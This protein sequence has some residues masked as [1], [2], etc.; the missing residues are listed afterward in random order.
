MGHKKMN[1]YTYHYGLKVRIYPS[2]RQKEMIRRNSDAARSVYNEMV[3][4]NKEISLFGKLNLHI[5]FIAKRIEELRDR[6]ATVTA[7]KNRFPWLCH[8]DI[9]AQS[10]ANARQNYQKAWRQF[11]K[12]HTSGVPRFHKKEATESYQTNPH[13][14]K[15]KPISLFTSNACF[16]D[17]HHL[18]LPKLKRIRFQCSQKMLQKIFAMETKKHQI[19]RIGTITIAK[20]VTGD[21]FASFQLGS[22]EPFVEPFV[23]TGKEVGIDL[24]IENFYADSNG[25]ILDNPSYY[26]RQ[27]RR[28]VNAQRKLSRRIA[29]AKKEHRSIHQAKNIEKQR[30]ILAKL[31][32]AVKR[33]RREFLQR[34]STTLIKNHD[35]V[36][37]EELRS[38]NMLKN[39]ALAMCIQDNGWR[40]FLNMLEYKAKLHQ[41]QFVTVDPRN[42][43]QTCHNC[44]HVMRGEQ[45]L[46]LRDREWTCPVCGMYHI[47][48]INAAKNILSKG[49]AKLGLT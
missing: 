7:L 6:I 36:V 5:D 22:D 33:R 32:S 43:T 41:R 19:V 12:V 15:D 13:Y 25:I 39:H 2:N 4:T 48:D 10:I 40:M 38:K 3:G 23:P 27:K 16:L 35:L 31:T 8:P 29:R 42:T 28:I 30:Q 44:G 26:R 49:K 1:E 47:R 37:A 11:R 45:K 24:N 14:A 21:Y 18:M 17:A 9:D 46:T 20:D 34:T